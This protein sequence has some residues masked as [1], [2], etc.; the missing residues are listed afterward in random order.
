ME[1]SK[2]KVPPSK[3]IQKLLSFVKPVSDKGAN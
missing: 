1:D 2:L 3:K